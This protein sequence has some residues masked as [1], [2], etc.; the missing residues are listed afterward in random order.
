MQP[1]SVGHALT[2]LIFRYYMGKEIKKG[3]GFWGKGSGNAQ[4]TI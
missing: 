4:E 2:R 3:S 1:F